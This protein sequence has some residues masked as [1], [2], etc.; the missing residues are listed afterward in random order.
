M[1]SKLPSLSICKSREVYLDPIKPKN[2]KIRISLFPNLKKDYKRSEKS[3]SVPPLSTKPGISKVSSIWKENSSSLDFQEIK[4]ESIKWSDSSV[5]H[6]GFFNLP[7]I[8]KKNPFSLDKS[9][10]SGQRNQSLRRREE[11]EVIEENTSVIQRAVIPKKYIQVKSP[12]AFQ[13]TS[14][15]TPHEG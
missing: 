4:F 9:F 2:Q 14:Y 11:F 7:S 8:Q 5:I 15:I 12:W 1:A 3:I 6:P 10:Y 13:T